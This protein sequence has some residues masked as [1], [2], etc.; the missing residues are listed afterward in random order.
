MAGAPAPACSQLA[1]S[2]VTC[3]QAG[4]DNFGYVG[5]RAFPERTGVAALGA[6]AWNRC[7]VTPTTK[8]QQPLLNVLL[9]HVQVNKL[10]S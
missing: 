5:T 3:V 9:G 2:Y 10:F 8:G 6:A 7:R 1:T 4:L